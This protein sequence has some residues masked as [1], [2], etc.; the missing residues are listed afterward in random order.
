[1]KHWSSL[2][3]LAAF[4]ALTVSAWAFANRPTQEPAWPVEI[5]GF[6]FQPFQKDQDAIAG[7]LPTVEQIDR[8]LQL[9]EGKT[10]S[11][12]TYSS[13]GTLGDVP[14][15]ARKYG[16]K[17]TVGAWLSDDLDLNRR[18]VDRLIQVAKAN[19]NVNQLIVGN[20]VV[21]RH[22]SHIDDLAPDELIAHL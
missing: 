19:P 16:I 22:E 3:I 14:R 20:E 2:L 6:S 21:L 15:L 9:L 12:R 17:V 5:D 10:A 11:V 8:D 7:D 13:L 18:E 1:M 4:A